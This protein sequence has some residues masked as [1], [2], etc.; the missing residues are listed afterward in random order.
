MALPGYNPSTTLQTPAASQA[1]GSV[2]DSMLEAPEYSREALR[3]NDLRKLSDPQRTEVLA[4]LCAKYQLPRDDGLITTIVARDGS[5]KPYVTAAGV[6][7]LSRKYVKSV[8]VE[9]VATG[10]VSGYV[11]VKATATTLDSREFES[12]GCKRVESG[13]H[14]AIM[15]A[16]TAARVRACKAA[17]GISLMTYAEAASLDES[18]E[19]VKE[20]QNEQR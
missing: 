12:F 20:N 19:E 15:Q 9:I 16:D 13:F 17:V 1:V 3:L 7:A 11:V 5:I 8:R 18:A 4:Y 6:F 2:L 14:I 10:V